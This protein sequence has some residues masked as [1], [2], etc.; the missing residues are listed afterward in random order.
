M[1][2]GEP[3]NPRFRVTHKHNKDLEECGCS[4]WVFHAGT[5]LQFFTSGRPS[6]VSTRLLFRLDTESFV[7]I[8]PE[9][10]LTGRERLTPFL[11]PLSSEIPF[12]TAAGKGRGRMAQNVLV[13]FSDSIDQSFRFDFLVSPNLNDRSYGLI[14]LRDIVRHFS[15]RTEGPFRSGDDAVPIT[16]PDLVLIPHGRPQHI[17]YRCPKCSVE[18][19]GVPGLALA[20]SDCNRPLV[21]V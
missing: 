19:W 12:Q 10:W 5:T 21:S 3:H 18:A 20:C 9:R 8:I 13:R 14:S 16:L 15:I 6:K 7:S 2:D 1:P 17:G 4:P 11:G